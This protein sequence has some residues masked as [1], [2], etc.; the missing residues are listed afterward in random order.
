ME[1]RQREQLN[2]VEA[3]LADSAG[4]LQYVAMANTLT[5][6]TQAQPCDKLIRSLTEVATKTTS[7]VADPSADD[8][9]DDDDDD[10]DDFLQTIYIILS[11]KAT[12]K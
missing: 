7:L 9:D 2:A 12:P 4:V 10:D 8:N 1:F 11:P 3:I 5:T 6:A